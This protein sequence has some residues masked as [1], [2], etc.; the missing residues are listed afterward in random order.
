MAPAVFE[1]NLAFARQKNTEF[2]SLTAES[3]CTVK[4]EPACIDGSFA[5]CGEAQEGRFALHP[6]GAGQ[7]CFAIPWAFADLVKV[8][9]W[10]T[11]DAEKILGQDATAPAD[12][13]VEQP[14]PPASPTVEQPPAEEPTSFSTTTR[15]TFITKT[16]VPTPPPQEP[17]PTSVPAPAAPV[18]EAPVVPEQ[19]SPV[20]EEPAPTPDPQ[21]EQPAPAPEDTPPAGTTITDIIG[22]PVPTSTTTSAS[23]R[24]TN[25]VPIDDTTSTPVEQPQVAAPTQT[26]DAGTE[27]QAPV[28]PPDSAV[29]QIIA[30]TPTVS[31]FFTVTVTEKERETVTLIVPN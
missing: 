25:V 27:E 15:T 24:W 18:P 3:A 4:G 23:S 17:A 5:V 22:D 9:C 10:D 11:A 19:P 31:L 2:G 6:C 21:P 16:V 8:G 7:A 1:T 30:G 29:T 13:S 12:P 14:P 26:A 28:S 20:P